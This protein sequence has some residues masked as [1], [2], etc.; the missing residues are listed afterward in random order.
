[1]PT[2][3]FL[4]ATRTVTGSKYLLDFGTSRLLVDCGLFQGLKELR[5]RNWAEHPV[6]ASTIE[7]VVLTHAHLDHCGYLPRLVAQGFRGRIFCTAGTAD[8]CRLVLP[9]AAR[10]AEEDARSANKHGY[11]RHKPALPLF[12]EVDAYRAISQLQPVG[13]RRPMPVADGVHVEFLDAGHLLG[14]SFV[15][16]TLRRRPHGFCSAEI[17]AGTAGPCCPIPRRWLRRTCCSSSRPTAIASTSPTTTGIV[18]PTIISRTAGRGG[19]LLIPSFAIGRVEELVYWIKRAGGR[20]ADSGAPGLHRQPDGGRGVEVLLEP[21]QRS[22][23]GAASRRAARL[24]VLHDA[25]SHGADGGGVEEAD[26]PPRSGDRH[27]GERHGD[28]RPGAPPPRA[29]AA[30]SRQTRSCSS[31]TRRP[32][33]AAG[34]WSRASRR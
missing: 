8:L 7:S 4:G 29:D 12:T 21:R 14:S 20:E 23:S 31:A 6:D 28:R 16:M 17:S 3:K 32:A 26:R 5:L 11:S 24:R 9:D 19:R 33:R 18:L 30:R 15:R 25:L 22:G 1:M 27:L 2:L 13:Y 34:G 10:I